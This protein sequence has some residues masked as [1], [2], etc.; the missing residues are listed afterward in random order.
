MSAN[1]L[2][3][4]LRKCFVY[5]MSGAK[6]YNTQLEVKYSNPLVYVAAWDEKNVW[7]YCLT[8]NQSSKC[9]VATFCFFC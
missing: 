8:I 4:F 5:K 6:Q 1:Q 3:T 2:I 9:V 7:C